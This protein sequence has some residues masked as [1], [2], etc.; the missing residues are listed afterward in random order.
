MMGLRLRDGIERERIRNVFGVE[1]GRLIPEPWR[2]T[3]P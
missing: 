2:S 1:P 3:E